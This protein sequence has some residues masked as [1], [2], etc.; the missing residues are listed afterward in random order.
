MI[1][2]YKNISNDLEDILTGFLKQDCYKGD[3]FRVTSQREFSMNL[4]LRYSK[5]L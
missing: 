4:V 3:G 1:V 2:R 5:L